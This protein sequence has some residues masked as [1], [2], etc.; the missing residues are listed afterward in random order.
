MTS[1]P[2]PGGVAEMATQYAKMIQKA[3]PNSAVVL[4]G[5]S[6]TTTTTTTA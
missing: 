5:V 4:G 2:W 6:S 3:S 1:Q